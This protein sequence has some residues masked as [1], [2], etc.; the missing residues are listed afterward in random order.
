MAD[1]RMSFRPLI[2]NTRREGQNIYDSLNTSV[3]QDAIVW[4]RDLF[5]GEMHDWPRPKGFLIIGRA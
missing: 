2:R 4:L 5:G 3:A 1:L